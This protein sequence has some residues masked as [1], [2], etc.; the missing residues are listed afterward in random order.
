MM[1]W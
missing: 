1:K